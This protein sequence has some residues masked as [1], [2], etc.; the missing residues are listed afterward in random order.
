[1]KCW[2]AQCASFAFGHLKAIHPNTQNRKVL[3][4]SNG[5]GETRI[6]SQQIFANVRCELDGA[7]ARAEECAEVCVFS[8]YQ[9]RRLIRKCDGPRNFHG[10]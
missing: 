4:G 10:P 5:G 1:M 6:G 8:T 7:C 9:S 3:E 2:S